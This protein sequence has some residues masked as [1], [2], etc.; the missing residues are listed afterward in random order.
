MNIHMNEFHSVGISL[1]EIR[2]LT[3]TIL[4]VNDIFFVV[5]DTCDYRTSSCLEQVTKDTNRIMNH[6]W[7]M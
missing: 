3:T 4:I 7:Q 6:M 5:N 1:K 2:K